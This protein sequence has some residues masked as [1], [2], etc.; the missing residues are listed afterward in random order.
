MA[1]LKHHA[2]AR[3][4]IVNDMD[5]I[6]IGESK[7]YIQK[8]AKE[9]ISLAIEIIKKQYTAN[10]AYN[11][12]ALVTT[13]AKKQRKRV[14]FQADSRLYTMTIFTQNDEPSL[15]NLG[16]PVDTEPQLIHPET[17]S[18]MKCILKDIPTDFLCTPL[19]KILVQ[20]QEEE[21]AARSSIIN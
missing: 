16:L 11:K 17:K 2:S 6:D 13:D 5:V 18:I 8:D 12:S 15:V 7:K 4:K 14:R 1:K 19:A 20:K 9:I 3:L 21:R 10:K